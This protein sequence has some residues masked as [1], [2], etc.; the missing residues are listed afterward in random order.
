MSNTLTSNT[1]TY[2]PYSPV[3]VTDVGN[4]VAD[5]M[6]TLPPATGVPTVPT[7]GSQEGLLDGLSKLFKPKNITKYSVDPKTGGMTT[8]VEEGSIFSSDGVK[9][10][11]ALAAGLESGYTI[12]ATNKKLHQQDAQIKANI[13]NMKKNYGLAYAKYQNSLAE[14]EN[15]RKAAQRAGIASSPSKDFISAPSPDSKGK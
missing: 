2:D 10:L 5:A 1:F 11:G 9:G 14:K 3:Y 7:G 13:E 15:R 4:T 8:T 6:K 12:W